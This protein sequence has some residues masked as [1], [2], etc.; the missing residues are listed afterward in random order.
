M[1]FLRSSV[2]TAELAGTVP[3]RSGGACPRQAGSFGGSEPRGVDSGVGLLSLLR[4]TV[5]V[6]GIVL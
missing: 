2:G 3:L 1:R 5:R 6:R 4:L